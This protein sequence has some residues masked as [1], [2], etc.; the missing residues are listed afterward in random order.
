[1]H[2]V[3]IGRPLR[4]EVIVS[5]RSGLVDGEKGDEGERETEEDKQ[6]KE[7]KQTEGRGGMVESLS[8][9]QSLTP[10]L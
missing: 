2:N 1:M 4:A 3:L 10:C 9:C 7:D 8:A 5:G 6:T